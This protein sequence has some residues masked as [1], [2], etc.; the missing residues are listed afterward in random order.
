MWITN[1]GISKLAVVW[2]QTGDSPADIRGFIVD[3]GAPGFS[4]PEIKKKIGLRASVT[5]SIVLEDCEVGNDALMPGS[6]CGL[7]APLSCLSMA[8][9]GIAYGAIGAAM[10]CLEEAN[11]FT[12]TRKPFTKTL[13]HYQLIQAKS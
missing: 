8:R 6:D 13:D 1:G 7:K 10:G 3:R 11:E 5:S 4:T 2:A 12:S 9:F